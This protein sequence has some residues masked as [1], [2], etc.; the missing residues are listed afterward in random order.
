MRF[1]VHEER[2]ID[3]PEVVLT[4]REVAGGPD[5]HK[6]AG[7]V[8]RDP[9]DLLTAAG[10]RVDAELS[11]LRRANRVETLR[12]DA[13]ECTVLIITLPRDNE[14]AGGVDCH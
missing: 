12:E 9:G 8:H 4:L 1:V 10:G 13:P 14:I 2:E 3:L 7:I 6:F 11:S 5:N